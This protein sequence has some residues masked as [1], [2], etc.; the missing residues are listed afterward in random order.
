MI[1]VIAALLLS[2][3]VATPALA[4]NTGK[5]YIAGDLGAA[6]Y[7]NVTVAAGTYPNPGMVRIAG[8]YHFSPAL[9]VEL[10]ISGFG[11]STLTAGTSSGTVTASSFQIAAVGSLP[12]NSQFDLIGKVGIARNKNQI[13]VKPSGVTISSSQSSL[14]F[15]FGG[16]YHI[17]SQF[18]V[19]AQYENFGSFGSFGTTGQDMKVSA[20][21]VGVAYDF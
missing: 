8:G 4:D 14:L 15:G 11:D 12:L 5:Y 1:K 3:F 6:K 10:G 18:S 20:I 7:T 17:N 21:S 19:R 9:A 13:D 2:A 16:Q